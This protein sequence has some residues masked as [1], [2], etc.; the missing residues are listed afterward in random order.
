[1]WIQLHVLRTVHKDKRHQSN[2]GF[3][4]FHCSPSAIRRESRIHSAHAQDSLSIRCVN[5]W[6]DPSHDQ[7]IQGLWMFPMF[8]FP[9][10]TIQPQESLFQD[11]WNP[12]GLKATWVEMLQW[13][14]G[15]EITVFSIKHS[16]V[17]RKCRK[18]DFTPFPLLTAATQIIWVLHYMG[19]P[20]PE[21]TSPEMRRDRWGIDPGKICWWN[22]S[23]N[24]WTRRTNIYLINLAELC[25]RDITGILGCLPKQLTN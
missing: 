10:N 14:E 15:S 23:S 2:N 12:W 19:F 1:M 3:L 4:E 20:T 24:S 25:K 5:N 21:I 13:R 8:G 18:G 17:Y 22:A 11:S 6:L 16:W 7:W 9:S